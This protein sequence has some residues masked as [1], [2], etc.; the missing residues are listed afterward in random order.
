MKYIRF[1]TFLLSIA[2]NLRRSGAAGLP[3]LRKDGPISNTLSNP[4]TTRRLSHSSGAILSDRGRSGNS[5]ADVWNGLATA[6]PAT[7]AN[8]GVSTSMKCLS[9][10]KVRMY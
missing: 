1:R 2:E 9:R 5:V 4:L 6:P 3:S 10:K 8:I 7:D